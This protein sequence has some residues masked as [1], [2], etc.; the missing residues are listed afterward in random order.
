[1]SDPI[2]GKTANNL[3]AK[4]TPA[5]TDYILMAENKITKRTKI[6]DFL[7]F[8]KDKLGIN[9]L[10][11]NL[12][13]T[14]RFYAVSKFYVPGSSDNYSGLAIG[15]VA[16]NNIVGIQYVSATDYK[17]Y[18]T[19]PKG[20]YLVNINLFANLEAST[21]NVLGVAIKIE[22]D[23]TEIANPWFR[24][25]DSYQ[26]IS[27]PVIISGSKLKVTMYSG[28][29]IEIVNNANLSYIDFMRLN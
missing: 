4:T 17:H 6:S 16:W 20:T 15:G 23:D 1:M 21:S 7:T 8:L 12:G 3:T 22:V 28:K 14:A 26:S 29:A 9:T 10:N 27:Y 18:Y 25:I 13:K 11:T 19:F 2:G 5:E 24:M